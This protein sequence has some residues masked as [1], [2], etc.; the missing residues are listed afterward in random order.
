MNM[1]KAPVSS[2]LIQRFKNVG[3]LLAYWLIFV[4]IP[5]RRMQYVADNAHC[6]N[7]AN[8]KGSI[9]IFAFAFLFA[10]LMFILPYKFAKF[11]SK[12]E[13]RLYIFVGLLIPLIAVV[14]AVIG[15]GLTC[16]NYIF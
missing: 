14:S 9:G 10:M 3:L 2:K 4:G 7:A 12:I 11:P 1:K 8:D 13:K 6:A 15:S 16:A 5:Y